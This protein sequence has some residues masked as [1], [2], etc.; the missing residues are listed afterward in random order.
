MPDISRPSPR[1]C[2][3]LFLSDLHLGAL[4]AQPE[5]VLDFLKAHRA[6]TYVLV[7]DVLDLWQ[8]LL[9]HW[10]PEDQAVVDHL[11][12]RKAEGAT[13][14]YLRGNHDPRPERAP[15]KARPDAAAQD[16]I[17]HHAA[18]GRRYLV[19]H[20][21]CVDSRF[22]RAHVFTRLG[23]RIDH[24]LRSL[25][26]GLKR[27][28]RQSPGEARSTIE[29]LLVWLSTLT[30]MSRTHEKR[31]V[32]L[33]RAEGL[34]GVICGHFHLAALHDEHGLVYANCGDWVDSVSGVIESFDGA[35]QLLTAP[36]PEPAPVP[37]PTSANGDLVEA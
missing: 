23:S 28:W 21:D 24:A 4:G 5:R 8:P 19:I 37:A 26:R 9:P 27:L 31:L 1:A 18:D 13:L 10:T 33:A 17:I 11:N 6:E 2:R 14:I 35:L 3:T 29:T 36:H 34:D 16:R 30:H 25:D 32:D 15:A 7:G 20:G 12:Q 22:F